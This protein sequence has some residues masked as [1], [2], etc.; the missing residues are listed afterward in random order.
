MGDIAI[1]CGASNGHYLRLLAGSGATVYGFEPDPHGF[2]QLQ[3]M[4]S[5][6]LNV[7]LIE[8]AVGCEPKQMKLHRH[9]KFSED[10][11]YYV[12]S[13]SVFT[14]SV[15]SVDVDSVTVQQ[16]DFPAFIRNLPSRVSLLKLDIEGAEVPILETLLETGLI[17]RVDWV[18]AETHEAVVPELA[19]RTEALKLRVAHE[20]RTNISLDWI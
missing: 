2:G 10:P 11:D 1:D 12:H 17:D 19:D 9:A 20:G 4:F 6:V 7:H 18:F 8:K 3:E 5:G 14:S 16:I 15:N 13:S